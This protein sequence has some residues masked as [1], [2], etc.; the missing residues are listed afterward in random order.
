M[1]VQRHPTTVKG[2]RKLSTNNSLPNALA[3][4]ADE[5]IR[6]RVNVAE[7][8]RID[9]SD[10]PGTGNPAGYAHAT[11]LVYQMDAF[12]EPVPQAS[13]HH[14][15]YLRPQAGKAALIMDPQ[16]GDKA[17]AVFMNRDSS[18][19]VTSTKDIVQPKT[20]RIYDLSDGY[21]INGFLGDT[22]EI[23]L[24]FSDPTGAKRACSRETSVTGIDSRASSLRQY[25]LIH[26]GGG[27]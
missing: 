9:R 6:E 7:V 22:P 15:P 25:F 19:V 5:K 8:V 16:P 13:I 1:S 10:Q 26:Q 20:K 2:F 12:D 23:W 24:E 18:N 17:I 4:L 27:H 3:F 21:L 11:P 14:L